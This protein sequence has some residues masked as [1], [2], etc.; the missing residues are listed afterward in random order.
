MLG[1]MLKGMCIQYEKKLFYKLSSFLTCYLK[2]DYVT[3]FKSK[4]QKILRAVFL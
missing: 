4:H 2:Q 3:W 1:I